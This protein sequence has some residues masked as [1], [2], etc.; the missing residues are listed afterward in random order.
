MTRQKE[1]ISAKRALIW[2]QDSKINPILKVHDE[3]DD[4]YKLLWMINNKKQS[5][6]SNI[7]CHLYP[8]YLQH[9]EDNQRWIYTRIWIILDR[10]YSKHFNYR[11]NTLTVYIR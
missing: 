2:I 9:S 5:V 1:I 11:T 10:I 8:F 7:A 3:T 6:L 4:W